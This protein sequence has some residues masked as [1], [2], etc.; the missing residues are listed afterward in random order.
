MKSIQDLN[1]PKNHECLDEGD[2]DFPLVL[3]SPSGVDEVES[4]FLNNDIFKFRL[5]PR[6][7]PSDDIDRAEGDGGRM[8]ASKMDD[9]DA[10]EFMPAEEDD[11]PRM[12]F[13][14]CF[15]PQPQQQETYCP[16]TPP[17]P[18]KLMLKP[19]ARVRRVME[20]NFKPDLKPRVRPMPRRPGFPMAM[21][22]PQQE[23]SSSSDS[24]NSATAV[25]AFPFLRTIQPTPY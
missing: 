16:F 10:M 3:R 2:D 12:S 18:P 20:Q 11:L 25:P 14:P 24:A 8:A 17:P 23:S 9:D 6:R 1:I 5:Q 21:P 19:N 15:P 7:P 4:D 13:R 22:Q